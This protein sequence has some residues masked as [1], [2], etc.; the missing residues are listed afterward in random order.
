MRYNV[1]EMNLLERQLNYNNIISLLLRCS[2]MR[3]IFMAERRGE[4]IHGTR[5]HVLEEAEI[6]FSLLGVYMRTVA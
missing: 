2:F 6:N 1:V 3:I 4:V 5:M